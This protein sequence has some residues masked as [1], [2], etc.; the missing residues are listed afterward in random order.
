MTKTTSLPVR[1]GAAA[2]KKASRVFITGE[3]LGNRLLVIRPT[4]SQLKAAG[5]N[6]I[7]ANVGASDKA[8]QAAL[9]KQFAEI[10][11]DITKLEP[12]GRK[13]LVLCAIDPAIFDGKPADCPEDQITVDDLGND[14]YSLTEQL[15]VLAGDDGRAEEAATETA[16]FRQDAGGLSG[17]PSG[18]AVPAEPGRDPEA[19]NG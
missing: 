8:R 12:L 1:T 19:A 5:V 10:S 2:I 15:L 14:V 13:L 3:M 16:T 17:E 6:P 18:A 11:K 7:I 9:S 4:V